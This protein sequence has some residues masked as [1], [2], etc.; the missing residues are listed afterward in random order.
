M[1]LLLDPW[2]YHERTKHLLDDEKT[3]HHLDTVAWIEALGNA[4]LERSLGHIHS[5]T[6]TSETPG[7][8]K[9]AGLHSL[10]GYHHEKVSKPHWTYP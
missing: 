1:C 4:A 10:R 9:R 3:H 7:V 8:I 6:N 2:E 5:Y